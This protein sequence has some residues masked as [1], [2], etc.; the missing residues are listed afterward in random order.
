MRVSTSV[1]GTV[2]AVLL[3]GPAAAPALAA[4]DAGPD[5]ARDQLGHR[6]NNQGPPGRPAQ[7]HRAGDIVD[8]SASYGSDIVVT[9]RY[10]AF[11]TNGYTLFTWNFKT[12]DQKGPPYW[13]ATL[14]VKASR[15]QG[16]FTLVD[17]LANP[18]ACGGA[19][20]DPAARTV[21][22]TV[23]ASC[24]NSPAWVKVGNG[25]A[26]FNGVRDYWDDARLDGIV[27]DDWRFGPKLTRS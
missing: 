24:L 22:L 8:N 12:V 13:S 2:V 14:E 21:T 5:P 19:V 4:T 20:M 7:T 6:S 16:V 11:A 3:V 18:V 15:D 17:G 27:K 23:P 25:S 26:V 9:T 1:L 10:R